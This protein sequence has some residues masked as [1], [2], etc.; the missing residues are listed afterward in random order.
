MLRKANCHAMEP[1]G[2]CLIEFRGSFCYAL[3]RPPT[4]FLVESAQGI[5][6][7]FS[8]AFEYPS[9]QDI[10]RSIFSHGSDGRTVA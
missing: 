1:W 8:G 9:E 10:A 5:S 7:L 6:Q 2:E 4:A 3:G